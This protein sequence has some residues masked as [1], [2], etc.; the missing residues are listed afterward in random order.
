M[1]IDRLHTQPGHQL[2]ESQG[3]IFLEKGV[4]I[5]CV[6]N[7]IHNII[8]LLVASDHL[9][10]HRDIILQIGI[11]RNQRVRIILGRHQSGHQRILMPDITRQIK[12]VN[13]FARFESL[14]YQL[15]GTVAA[16][17]VNKKYAAVGAYLFF[18]Y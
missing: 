2:I 1:V 4:C 15:P 5:A 14:T 11:D 6:A 7:S 8:A 16:A 13:I 3:R 9:R 17:V 18:I 10:Y 12:P